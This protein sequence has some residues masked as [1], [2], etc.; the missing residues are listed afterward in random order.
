MAGY[1]DGT[2]EGRVAAILDAQPT[3]LGGE[4]P[5]VPCFLPWPDDD[6]GGAG[7]YQTTG[8]TCESEGGVLEHVELFEWEEAGGPAFARRP[9]PLASG[10]FDLDAADS[11]FGCDRV[12][13]D[14]P[15]VFGGGGGCPF[16]VEHVHAA[17][18]DARVRA[19]LLYVDA[20]D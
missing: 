7:R 2:W 18:D 11:S 6:G 4:D 16:A 8:R 14:L 19:L 1:H 12:G 10:A 15:G 3:A 20:G 13:A 17:D 9:T 5:R